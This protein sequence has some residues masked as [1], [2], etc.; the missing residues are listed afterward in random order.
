MKN[1]IILFAICFVIFCDTDLMAQKIEGTYVQDELENIKLHFSED[2]FLFNDVANYSHSA[3]Y[4]CSDTLA[5]GYWELDGSQSFIKLYTNPLQHASLVSMQ[6]E[7]TFGESTDSI[8]LHIRNPVERNFVKYNKENEKARIIYYRINIESKDARLDYEVNTQKYYSNGIVFRAPHNGGIKSIELSV[9]PKKYDTGWRSNMPPYF[10]YTL[11]YEPKNAKANIFN[12]NMPN[13]T[14][15]YLCTL[16]LNGDFIKI[17][18]DHQLE[19]DGHI[20]T[21]G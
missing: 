9:Y 10:V 3:P 12:I 19:W 4:N 15:C 14:G 5:F 20:Y 1:K 11:S 7:E 21:K 2:L 17:L 8:Y 18:N 16:R 6:V 13:L